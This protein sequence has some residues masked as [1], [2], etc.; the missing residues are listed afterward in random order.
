MNLLLASLLLAFVFVVVMIVVHLILP[1][2][3]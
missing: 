1:R 2:G 3:D